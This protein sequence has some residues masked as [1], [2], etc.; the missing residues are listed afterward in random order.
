MIAYD[1][2]HE[3]LK[4]A[5]LPTLAMTAASQASHLGR[6]GMFARRVQGVA[7]EVVASTNHALANFKPK[8]PA[9]IP[10]PAPNAIAQVARKA[11][12]TQA[13]DGMALPRH[14]AK[15]NP[16][17]AI[18]AGRQFG[19]KVVGNASVLDQLSRTSFDKLARRR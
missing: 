6:A 16:E 4:T 14:L 7:P 19:A 18:Q 1:L 12:P 15:T 10:R 3:R 8:M 5:S 17:Q 9:A 13:I 11:T 2:I